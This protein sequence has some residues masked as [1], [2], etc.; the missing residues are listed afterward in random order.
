L[1]NNNP[2]LFDV[3]PAIDSAG[4][5]SFTT[6]LNTNGF[7]VV[8]AFARDNGSGIAPNVSDSPAVTF[9]ITLTPV[10]DAPIGVDDLYSTTED[11]QLIST[12]NQ[13]VL[14][15]DSDPDGDSFFA[16][17]GE[18]VS[19]RGALVTMN[20][21]GSFVYDPRNAIAIQALQNGQSLQDT[22]TYRLIDVNDAVSLP[23]TVTVTVAGLN[24]APRTMDDSLPITFNQP[25]VLDVLAN[26][27]DVDSIINRQSLVIGLVPLNGRVTVLTDGRVSYV[28]NTGYRGGDSFTYQVRDD[29]GALSRETTVQLLMNTPPVANPDSISTVVGTSITI[30]VVAN[31]RDPDVGDTINRQSVV[32]V[33]QSANGTAVVL[34]NG[35][36]EFTPNPGFVGPATVTYTVADNN[37][38]RSNIGNVNIDVV[39]SLFQNPRNRFDVN[40]DTFVSPIDAL[41]VINYLNLRPVPPL[42]TTLP[43][44]FL[45][46]DGSG[47]VSAIDVLQVIN[48]LNAR[49]NGASAEGESNVPIQVVSLATPSINVP[50][51]G[52][53]DVEI[54]DQKLVQAYVDSQ[55]SAARSTKVGSALWSSSSAF[56]DTAFDAD[57]SLSAVAVDITAEALRR[58]LSGIFDS[59]LE[60]ALNDMRIG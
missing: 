41:I 43:P 13:D 11:A 21:N 46:V 20:A 5:L 52:T 19:L 53:I 18:S 44:N 58:K 27:T 35:N 10:N 54:L 14:R 39:A 12:A 8:T 30:D 23:V 15:N 51:S 25:T 55:L 2:V 34:A 9:T 56:A 6:R 28:P 49:V 3:Q 4:R 59:A 17:A 24:D 60:D 33:S 37:G 31:D 36:I 38:L 7:A 40:N 47:F 50:I 42:S 1:T 16:I 45:D 48:F 57:E 32:I 26:D 22:F 29:F